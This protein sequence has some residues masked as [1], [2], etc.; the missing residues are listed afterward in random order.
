MIFETKANEP[1][2]YNLKVNEFI[3]IVVRHPIIFLMAI[4]NL[5]TQQSCHNFVAPTIP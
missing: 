3:R 2:F 4:I 5:A 1:G